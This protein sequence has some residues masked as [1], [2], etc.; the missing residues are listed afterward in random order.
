MKI[1]LIFLFFFP[2]FQLA[3]VPPGDLT[4]SSAD[5]E[6]LEEIENRIKTSLFFKGKVA[7]VFI[8]NGLHEWIPVG[9][10]KGYAETREALI[11][12]IGGNAEK[13]A[14]IYLSA[15]MGILPGSEIKYKMMKWKLN[16]H[17]A[18]LIKELNEAA[19][20]MSLS[21]EDLNLVSRRL[22][23]GKHA[24]V[25]YVNFDLEESGPQKT[26]EE[27]KY[28]GYKVNRELLGKE[29]SEFDEYLAL[30]S[31]RVKAWNGDKANLWPLMKK[32]GFFHRKF[33]E[34][35]L[36]LKSSGRINEEQAKLLE[37]LRFS[38]RGQF[39]IT[40]TAF[41][42]RRTESLL[43][44]LEA[45][46][47]EKFS[48]EMRKAVKKILE[49]IFSLRA[50][51]MGAGETAEFADTYYLPALGIL[52]AARVCEYLLEL[53]EKSE[54]TGFSCVYDLL[55]FRHL[56]HFAPSS[57]YVAAR[58]KMK[59]EAAAI[60]EII[61]GYAEGGRARGELERLIKEFEKTV[62]EVRKT[63]LYNAAVQKIFWN[64][65]FQIFRVEMDGNKRVKIKENFFPFPLPR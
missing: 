38:A 54:K 49:G 26:G 12:W 7:D 33:S 41:I 55:V 32:A 57:G 59:K 58:E 52:N 50:E 53:K 1:I 27:I 62:R 51:N 6:E 24:P 30:L 10:A 2:F 21:K 36:A 3:A 29:M 39:L 31:R 63:S 20:D 47:V 16:P 14:R 61:G 4:P 17:F 13:A 25:N 40:E 15:E 46:G 56:S 64:S 28:A 23:E 5:V 34:A 37:K 45:G 44:R 19:A 43:G 11:K 42:A 60:D 35:A 9:A 48:G 8:E 65:A 22:F 18:G